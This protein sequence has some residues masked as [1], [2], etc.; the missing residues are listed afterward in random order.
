[1]GEWVSGAQSVFLA[2]WLRAMDMCRTG[3][4]R[5][6]MRR[7]SRPTDL[8]S[9]GNGCGEIQAIGQLLNERLPRVATAT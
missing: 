6:L 3:G 5:R 8:F 4:M 7:C 9:L 2:A 1:M